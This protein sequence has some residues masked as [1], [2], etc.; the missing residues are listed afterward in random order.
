[1]RR[2]L[3]IATLV[4]Y[5]LMLVACNSAS[6]KLSKNIGPT[7][8]D[9]K[10]LAQGAGAL[11]IEADKLWDELRNI[12]ENSSERHEPASKIKWLTDIAANYSVYYETFC[13]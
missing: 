11:L 5:S 9:C 3:I 10:E 6:N 8:Q 4:L 2:F 12:P 13:K 7:K 1:M